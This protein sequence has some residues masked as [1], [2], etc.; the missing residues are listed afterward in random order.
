MTA[1]N[2]GQTSS[3]ALP[4]LIFTCDLTHP[5]IQIKE[6][7]D[8]RY[9]GE[10]SYIDLYDD[11][12]RFREFPPYA[13][14]SAPAN[15]LAYRTYQ[16]EAMF[17]DARN[18][19]LDGRRL[20]V[21]VRVGRSKDTFQIGTQTHQSEKGIY[22]RCPKCGL[23]GSQ[24]FFSNEKVDEFITPLLKSPQK[25]NGLGQLEVEFRALLP[26]LIGLSQETFL[27]QLDRVRRK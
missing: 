17:E 13:Q 26:S 18:I 2:E 8:S 22:F 24:L 19:P 27:K 16:G 25:L 12:S 3:L 11:P 10:T 7:R 23:A 15:F 21:Q 14:K 5:K 6:M 9:F 4:T 20:P 1:N